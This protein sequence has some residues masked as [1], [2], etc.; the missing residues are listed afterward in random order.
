MKKTLFL[1][2]W[3]GTVFGSPFVEI[4]AAFFM[5]MVGWK[6]FYNAFLVSGSEILASCNLPPELD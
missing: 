6:W 2:S 3:G 5:R 4:T 1:V